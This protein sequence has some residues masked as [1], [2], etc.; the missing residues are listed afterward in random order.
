MSGNQQNL[1]T[2][3]DQIELKHCYDN[4]LLFLSTGALVILLAID[5][6]EDYVTRLNE[7]I[8][9]NSEIIGGWLRV[10]VDDGIVS[11]ILIR[12]VQL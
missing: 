3:V 6:I 5:E 4:E 7:K 2:S 12:I 11:V 1:T 9:K 10:F 8:H